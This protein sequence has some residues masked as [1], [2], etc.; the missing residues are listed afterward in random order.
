MTI[1]VGVKNKRG[2]AVGADSRRME[3]RC[4][5]FSDNYKE[6]V[7]P[8]PALGAVGACSGLLEFS[9]KK[10]GEWVSDI[11]SRG[12]VGQSPVPFDTFVKQF[13]TEFIDEL[14]RISPDEVDHKNRGV[15]VI[16][17]KPGF[18]IRSLEFKWI[19][20]D[21]TCKH[22]ENPDW[23][24]AGDGGAQGGAIRVLN[25]SMKPLPG[26]RK[27][28]RVIDQKD[29]PALGRLARDAVKGGTQSSGQC[30]FGCGNLACGGDPVFLTA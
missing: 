27:P 4:V 24:V 16:L 23:L 8:I 9:G 7:F 11:A 26:W 1:I 30:S 14:H 18:L 19:G 10:V 20:S 2:V 5:A 15:T 28:V 21:F 25:G 3:D 12:K 13:E 29:L 6:K 17:A 22:L